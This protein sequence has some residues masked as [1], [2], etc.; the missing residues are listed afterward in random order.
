MV[1][2]P[3]LENVTEL[4]ASKEKPSVALTLHL[5]YIYILRL[6]IFEI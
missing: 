2:I 4:K 5:H 3:L 6:I 1:L